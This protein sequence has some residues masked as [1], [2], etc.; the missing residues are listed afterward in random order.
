V[1]LGFPKAVAEKN[2]A[3]VLKKSGGTI[4]LEEL[5]KASLKTS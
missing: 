5:I 4:S 1:T 2:I 3:L